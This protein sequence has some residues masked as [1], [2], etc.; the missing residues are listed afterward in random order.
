MYDLPAFRERIAA[1]YRRT[2]PYD[3]GRRPTQQDLADAIGLSRSELSS[4]LNGLRHARLL[5]RDIHA[6]ICTLAEWGAITTQV[7]TWELLALVNCPD[8]TAAEWQSAPLVD[9]IATPATLSAAPVIGSQPRS[10]LP[11]II[12]SFVGRSRELDE[13]ARLIPYRR[14]VTLTGVGGAGK[15]R[16]AIE[17]ASQVQS[18]FAHGVC[19][20]E[21]ASQSNPEM[22]A[23]TIARAI[24]VKE[25]AGQSAAEA[26][27]SFIQGRE[28]LLVLDNCEHLARAVATLVRE[29]L[30]TCLRLHVLTTSRQA[31]HIAGE[32]VYPMPPLSLPREDAAS[33]VEGLISSEAVQLFVER[34]SAHPAFRL[35]DA[36]AAVVRTICGQLDGIPLALELAAARLRVLSPTQLQSQLADRFALLADRFGAE[37]RHQT[38]KGTI[39]WSYNLLPVAEQTLFRRLAVFSGGFTLADVAG[40][41]GMAE[42]VALDTLTELLDQSLIY[43]TAGLEDEPRFAMLETIREYALLKLRGAGKEETTREQHANYYLNLA[44]AAEPELRGTQQPLWLAR[45]EAEHDNISAAL[46]WL[47]EHKAEAGLRI[48]GALWRFWYMRGH[49]SVG[50]KWLEAALAQSDPA[51]TL[52]RAKALNGAAAMADQQGDNAAARAMHKANLAIRQVLKDNKGIAQTLTN[53]ANATLDSGDYETARSLY[54]QSLAIYRELNERWGMAMVLSNLENLTYIQGGYGA[55]DAY[56]AESMT[57]SRELGE[58]W[59]IAQL[60]IRKGEKVRREGSYATARALLEE[61]LSIKR[62]LEDKLGVALAIAGLGHVARDEGD[63]YTARSLFAQALTT[64][65]ELGDKRRIV[66]SLEDFAS[67][68]A[69]Q[70]QAERAVRLLAVATMLRERL[71]TPPLPYERDEHTHVLAAARNQL[72]ETDFMVAWAEGQ[73]MSLEQAA[74]YALEQMSAIGEAI[75]P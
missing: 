30:T 37:P 8:F 22:V 9:L 68:A 35:N 7:E 70:H 34:A 31:L 55:S 74:T 54:E 19:F 59:L 58:K 23:Q 17:V 60:L 65:W 29:L 4:R 51:P 33:T 38:L 27:R 71:G 52:L 48:S 46:G 2:A 72:G 62:A 66:H 6:I 44:E 14:L 57:I 32:V 40:M 45:L 73:H 50:R 41:L 63:Y 39:D 53:L 11:Y 12:T 61:S 49:I 21:L 13:L 43:Q 15:T 18:R 67:L 16:L 3:E 1:L 56:Y 69:A 28:L 64:K 24:G 20:V 75:Y 25:Q 10:N 47:I 42:A 5:P 26:L 36:N